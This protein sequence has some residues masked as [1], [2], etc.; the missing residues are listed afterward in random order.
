MERFYSNPIGVIWSGVAGI[1]TF[2][3]GALVV[4][5]FGNTIEDGFLLFAVSGGIGGLL[6]SIMTGLWKKIPVVTL[7]CFIGLPLGV[8]VSFGIAG[9]F[10][11]VPVLPESFSSS[12]MPDA[13]AIAIVGAVCGAILGGVLFG[14]HAVVFSALISGLAAF[15]FGLLVSAFN[16]DYPIRSL[17]MELIS[18]FH[19]Q[20]PNYVAIVMGVGIGMSLSL[21]LYRR[22]HPIPSKQ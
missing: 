8:L 1:V 17:F 14:R 9:L 16:K 19:A 2:T 5:L 3:F 20:D 13:F 18:P 10:D 21:G 7:V 4:S 11:L 6:L 12:G 15:P 22:N